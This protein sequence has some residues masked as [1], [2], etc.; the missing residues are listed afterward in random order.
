MRR[1]RSISSSIFAPKLHRREDLVAAVVPAERDEAFRVG[2]ETGVDVSGE[3]V[4]NTALAG[5]FTCCLWALKPSN[6]AGG[7]VSFPG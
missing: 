6:R 4:R 1:L 7:G 2:G 3:E 5:I